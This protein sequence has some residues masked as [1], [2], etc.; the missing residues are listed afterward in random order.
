M[1]ATDPMQMFESWFA[2]AVAAEPQ[3]PDAACLATVDG[4]GRPSSRIV[5]VK[6]HDARGFV[7]YTNLE[8]RKAVEIAANA[9]AALCFY[10]KS[11]DRQIRIEGAIEAVDDAEAD[12]YFTTRARGS[13]TGAWASAQSRPLADR[14]TL[15]AAFAEA[16]ARF[17]DADVPRPPFWSGLRLVARRIEFWQ[18]QPSRL[19]DRLVF[20]CDGD[21][22]TE[23]RLYP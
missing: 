7:F 17:I 4:D 3:T 16:E 14:A 19:H 9:Q 2:K 18:Q 12:A 1:D 21:G 8:S 10:W 11:L 22:W 5:L 20:E 6:G 13:Q 15:E 23:Q